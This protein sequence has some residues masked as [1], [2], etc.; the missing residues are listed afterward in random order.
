MRSMSSVK[1]AC[2][3]ALCIA[4]CYIL[5]LAFHAFGTGSMFSPMHI[6]VLLCG[7]VC[8]GGYGLFCGLAGPVLSSVLSGMPKAVG[9]ITMVPELCTYGLISG[10]LLRCVRTGRSLLDLYIALL[11]AMIA[12]RVLGGIASA[13]FYLGSAGSYSIAMWAG[14]YLL[15][16]LPG[17]AVQ[18]ILVPL[19]VFALEKT[20]AIPPRYPLCKT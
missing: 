2:T 12:G 20:G 3:C 5:P 10:L 13:L 9:L 4:F 19:L 16:T 7:L 11:S 6:P 8:G 1:R 15:G 17:I 14:S 18:L